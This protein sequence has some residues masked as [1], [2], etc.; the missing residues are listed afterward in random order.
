MYFSFCSVT[1]ICLQWTLLY[2][3][4][5]KNP[6]L[7]GR[8]K[9]WLTLTWCSHLLAKKYALFFSPVWLNFLIF[10]CFKTVWSQKPLHQHEPE[11][12]HVY[13]AADRYLYTYRTVL[14]L[15]GN[16]YRSNGN[17]CC[18]NWFQELT[19][20]SRHIYVNCKFYNKFS[21]KCNYSSSGGHRC[22]EVSRSSEQCSC[23]N[24]PEVYWTRINTYVLLIR[25]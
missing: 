3:R 4:R 16:M 21:S 5:L 25:C 7:V 18:H 17:S 19:F 6:L 9:S 12:I 15:S 2:V 1:F 24:S 11:C 13:V 20:K 23:N 8:W 22:L 14:L 10:L